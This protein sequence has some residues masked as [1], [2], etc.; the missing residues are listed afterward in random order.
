MP[1]ATREST[2]DA[3]ARHGAGDS[4]TSPQSSAPAA[5]IPQQ[6]RSAR[7]EPAPGLE[8][9]MSQLLQLVQGVRTGGWRPDGSCEAPTAIV[10][11][12]RSC[13]STCACAGPLDWPVHL[14]AV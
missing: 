6:Q 4:S 1:T 14:L 5:P 8:Q 7:S 13:G 9:R 3:E 2:H 11:E 12:V 10:S